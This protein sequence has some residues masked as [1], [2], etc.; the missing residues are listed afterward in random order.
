MTKLAC[1]QQ[2]EYSWVKTAVALLILPFSHKGIDHNKPRVQQIQEDCNYPGFQEECNKWAV[3]TK[4]IKK[5]NYQDLGCEFYL[6][7]SNISSK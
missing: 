7:F 3:P 5:K 2:F 1:V 4:L 6:F